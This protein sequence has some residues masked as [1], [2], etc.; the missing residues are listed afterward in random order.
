MHVFVRVHV[1]VHVH[2]HVR[3]RVCVCVCV[4]RRMRILK[5]VFMSIPQRR[6]TQCTLLPASPP[7]T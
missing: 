2:V 3:V 7:V 4:C 6:P 1:H 5:E